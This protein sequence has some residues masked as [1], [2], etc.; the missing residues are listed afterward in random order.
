MCMDEE[1]YVKEFLKERNDEINELINS[2][3][4]KKKTLEFQRLP[5]YKRRRTKNLNKKKKQNNN[6]KNKIDWLPMHIYYAKRFQMTKLN[7]FK[8]PLLR[9]Q[10][11]EKFIYKSAYRGFLM[12][13]GFMGVNIHK[14]N[15]YP[16]LLETKSNIFIDSIINNE[17][18]SYCKIN[19]LIIIQSL[20]INDYN[21]FS[22]FYG[23]ILIV[24]KYKLNDFNNIFK[25]GDIEN[26]ISIN[27]NYPKQEYCKEFNKFEEEYFYIFPTEQLFKYKIIFNKNIMKLLFNLFL[28]KGYIPICINELFRISI[29]SNII[30]NFDYTNTSFYEIFEK[31]VYNYEYEKYK[32]T[33]K[34]K[35][36]N[37]KAIGFNQPFNLNIKYPETHIFNLENGSFERG[38]LVY[39]DNI[40]CGIVIRGSFCFSIGK[41]RGII[42]INNYDKLAKYTIKSIKNGK[43]YEIKQSKFIDK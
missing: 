18:V 4:R 30:L 43:I 41:E 8:I 6:K 33:P 39:K 15:D 22:I 40:L 12:D 1:I 24:G 27:I 23:K 29:E 26:K 11:S 37:Y 38:S 3:D 21:I 17:P 14:I 13:E 7:G 28:I 9:R 19:D 16:N 42:S 36:K 20:L 35:R 34:G 25:N 10:K 5:F 2:L 32:R 31:A